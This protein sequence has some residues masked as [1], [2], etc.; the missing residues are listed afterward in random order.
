MS[1]PAPPTPLPSACSPV[2]GSPLSAGDR[3]C[4]PACPPALSLGCTL[5]GSLPATRR[6]GA[7]RSLLT[8][9]DTEAGSPHSQNRELET[10]RRGRAPGPPS[11][12]PG[13]CQPGVSPFL[14]GDRGRTLK[15]RPPGAQDPGGPRMRGAPEAV[16]TASPHAPLR[17]SFL[18]SSRQMGRAYLPG[19]SGGIYVLKSLFLKL[20]IVA[21]RFLH[22]K[23]CLQHGGLLSADLSLSKLSQGPEPPPAP[24]RG[25]GWRCAGHRPCGSLVRA[26][27]LPVQLSP[28]CWE[29]GSEA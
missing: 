12:S 9:E 16:A 25:W 4:A 7:G 2:S 13:F 6:P 8:D 14:P 20:T 3:G 21:E 27:G 5:E 28:R 18:N 24:P 29:P 22:N 11:E 1:P 26:P 23:S 17:L 19:G 15:V 10:P